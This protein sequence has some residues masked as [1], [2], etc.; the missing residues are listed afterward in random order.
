VP[1]EHSQSDAS[2]GGVPTLVRHCLQDS[3][4]LGG[5]VGQRIEQRPR[6][7]VVAVKAALCEAFAVTE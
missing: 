5:V 4:S 6:K 3:G 1:I 2:K 7:L